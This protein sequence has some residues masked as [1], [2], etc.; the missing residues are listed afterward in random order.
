MGAE[1]WSVF[2]G[3]REDIEAALFDLQQRE[4]EAGRYRSFEPD[5]PAESI[6]E[7]RERGD[8]DGT[9][10]VLDMRGVAEVFSGYDD[11]DGPGLGFVAPLS[12][13]QLIELY[14]TDKPTHA[15][16]EKGHDL[17]ERLDRGLGV[18]I[19]V[20]DGDTPSEL[21]FAGYSFD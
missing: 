21:F 4:F 20:Y 1:P 13:E 18:Y 8:A 12:H 16:V 3:Y 19:V 9:G 17:W 10:S 15:M 2:T 6:D 11:P 14:G 7:A 5:D